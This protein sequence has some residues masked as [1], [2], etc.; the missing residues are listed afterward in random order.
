M[1]IPVNGTHNVW[2]SPEAALLYCTNESFPSI[3][4]APILWPPDV[5]SRLI[6]KDRDAGKDWGQEEKGTRE[7]EMVGWHHWLNGHEFEQAPGDSEGQGSLACC[8]PW[9]AKSWTWLSN[10]TATTNGEDRVWHS[11]IHLWREHCF[12]CRLNSHQENALVR[13]R[14]ALCRR[15]RYLVP[16]QMVHHLGG[17]HGDQRGRKHMGTPSLSGPV[18]Q[19]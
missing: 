6:G 18:V 2:I 10:W 11:D 12:N 16:Q 13:M 19:T 14:W 4:E 15:N 7:D 17:T 9:F 8:S 1:L 3:G 5:K